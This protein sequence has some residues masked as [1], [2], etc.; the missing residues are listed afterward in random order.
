[1][2]LERIRG[3]AAWRMSMIPDASRSRE[4]SPATPLLSMVGPPAA[5][6]NEFAGGTVVTHEVDLVARLMFMQQ[7]H[8]TYAGTSTACT[9]VAARLP[10]TLVHE[11]MRVHNRAAIRIGHPAGVIE[12]ETVVEAGGQV[13]RATLGRTARRILEGYVFVPD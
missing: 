4:D 13:R 10:G 5:Y 8:K 9:G 12:T 7:M 3:V 11:V 2:L 6:R 1:M